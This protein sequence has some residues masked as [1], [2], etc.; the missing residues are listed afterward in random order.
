[1]EHPESLLNL[2]NSD[3]EFHSSETI[4]YSVVHLKVLLFE[5]NKCKKLPPSSGC[6]CRQKYLYKVLN[7][8]VQIIKTKTLQL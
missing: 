8:N 4:K 5:M 7:T 2:K 6:T 3:P 1:M